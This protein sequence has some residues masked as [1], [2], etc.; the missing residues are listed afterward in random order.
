MRVKKRVDQYYIVV[1]K[2]FLITS[3]QE[4]DPLEYLLP[5][6][7]TRK[8]PWLI[9]FTSIDA[10]KIVGVYPGFVHLDDVS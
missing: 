6:L 4:I 1:Y 3:V 2:N 7:F 8:L 9:N 10:G 5:I